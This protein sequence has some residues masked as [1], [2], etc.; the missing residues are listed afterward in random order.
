[1]RCSGFHQVSYHHHIQADCGL[2]ILGTKSSDLSL[3]IYQ[4]KF[5]Y[6]YVR[7][8][9]CDPFLPIC[10]LFSVFSQHLHVL[11]RNSTMS[12][13]PSN[14]QCQ[15]KSCSTSKYHT[16][17]VAKSCTNQISAQEQHAGVQASSQLGSRQSSHPTS[18]RKE[19]LVSRLLQSIIR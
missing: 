1:M 18:G 3:R 17:S 19:H 14:Y 12:Q 9:F 16:R 6:R 2:P 15:C 11:S 4:G 7:A 13:I 10:A 5:P 8:A